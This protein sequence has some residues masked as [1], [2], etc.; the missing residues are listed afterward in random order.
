[1]SPQYVSD[2]HFYCF[3]R[4][5]LLLVDE[6]NS[7]IQLTIFRL[8]PPQLIPLSQGGGPPLA[9]LNPPFYGGEGGGME[10]IP[11]LSICLIGLIYAIYVPPSNS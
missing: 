7:L 11:T 10:V 4:R 6:I 1:M 3:V 8:C 9:P 5:T 2:G